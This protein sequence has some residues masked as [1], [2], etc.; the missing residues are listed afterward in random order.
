MHI[1]RLG[2]K[3]LEESQASVWLSFFVLVATKDLA[4]GQW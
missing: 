2:A 1:K 3:T 4:S